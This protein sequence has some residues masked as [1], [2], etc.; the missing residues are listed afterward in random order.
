LIRTI[1][2]A[3]L[4]PTWDPNALFAKALR[5]VEHMGELDSDD[6]KQALWS[7]LSLELLARA[8]LANVNPILLADTERS[9]ASLYS[10]L[11]FTPT[12]EKFAPKS[13]PVNEVFK[14]LSAILPTFTKEYESFGIQHTGRRNAELHSGEA[15]FE[16]VKGSSWQSRFYQTCQ[17]LLASMGMTLEDFVGVHEAKIAS[18]L[19]AAVADESAKAVIGD[20]SAHKRVWLAKEQTERDTLATQAALWANRQ[21][22]HRVT[23]P[24]CGSPALVVGEPVAAPL[25]KL[26]GDEITETQEHLPNRFECI[27]CALK[28][29]GLSRLAAAGLADRYKKT[30]VYDAAEYYAPHDNYAGYEDDNNE[31]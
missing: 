30:Q 5:Y 31:Y 14:R 24:A 20:V 12:E 28:I 9:W 7:S 8:A 4:L 18:Q 13:I 22:G 16:G 10:A 19:I 3:A 1:T 25:Q 26:N 2:P 17:V 23:C 29:A 21:I 27:A 15:A 6:W 11:G